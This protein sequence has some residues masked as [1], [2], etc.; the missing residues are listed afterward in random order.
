MEERVFHAMPGQCAHESSLWL[1]VGWRPP[2]CAGL[3]A[4]STGRGLA[5]PPIPTKLPEPK[6]S[7]CWEAHPGGCLGSGQGMHCAAEVKRSRLPVPGVGEV[8]GVGLSR[9][10]SSA[11]W[12]ML[13][14]MFSG[15]RR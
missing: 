8:A 6:G 15:G 1:I 13:T 14:V 3:S 7:L 10:V 4:Q 5:H 11:S 12:E 2:H 9:Q